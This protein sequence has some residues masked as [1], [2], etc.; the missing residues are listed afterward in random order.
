MIGIGFI[1]FL[2]EQLLAVK[3]VEREKFRVIWD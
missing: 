3:R 2:I 1:P